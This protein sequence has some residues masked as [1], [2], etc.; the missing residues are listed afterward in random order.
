[1]INALSTAAMTSRSADRVGYGAVHV[2][3]SRQ[4]AGFSPSPGLS[5][6]HTALRCDSKA[7]EKFMSRGDPVPGAL[8]AVPEMNEP[9]IDLRFR[10][11]PQI[12]K[13]AEIR[14]VRAL[15]RNR[16]VGPVDRALDSFGQRIH[17][18]NTG[19]DVLGLFEMLVLVITVAEVEPEL[20][21]LRNGFGIAHDSLDTAF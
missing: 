14:S 12:R 16:H 4:L 1:M 11:H 2:E 8:D 7:R 15:D 10:L 20:D 17:Q 5:A 19:A 9:E 3:Q 21:S 6:A 13:R 18:S